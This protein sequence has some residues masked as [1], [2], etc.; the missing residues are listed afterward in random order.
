MTDIEIAKTELFEEN[1]TLA[2]V[3]N[4]VLLYSTKSHRISGFLEAIDRCG[5]N[6][7]GASVADR[8]VGKAVALLC[9]YARVKVVYAVVLSRKAL[10]VLKQSKVCV[11][12]NEL[13]EN[14]LDEKKTGVCPLEKA[15][16]QISSPDVA[17]KI[18]R[19]LR[20]TLKSAKC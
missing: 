7:C 14:V 10:S 16:A 19:G 2:V 17:F 13:V 20:E 4:G 1:L 11:F 15:A 8:V 3:K 6:L 5:E 18:L 12:W 9:A